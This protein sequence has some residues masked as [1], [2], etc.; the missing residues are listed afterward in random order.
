M[1]PLLLLFVAYLIY[2]LGY[3]AGLKEGRKNK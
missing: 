3:V 1:I 2:S